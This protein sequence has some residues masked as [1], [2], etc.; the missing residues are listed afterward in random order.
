MPSTVDGEHVTQE[1]LQ[2]WNA[3]RRRYP[4]WQYEE[5]FVV[6][7][8]DGSLSTSPV[9]LCEQL[10]GLRPGFTT[11]LS[12]GQTQPR[13]VALG[14][15]W[16]LPTAMWILFLLLLGSVQAAIPARPYETALH[17]VTNLWHC[18]RVP[19]GPPPRERDTPNI[20][21]AVLLDGSSTMDTA[22]RHEP[23][24]E[25]AGPH[26]ELV[27][28]TSKTVSAFV[29][30]SG[31]RDS[32]H[33]R[34]GGRHARSDDR[35]VPLTTSTCTICIPTKALSYA[36]T[37]PDSPSPTVE[38]PANGDLIP[39]A[40]AWIPT[41]GGTHSRSDVRQDQKTSTRLRYQNF[42]TKID[43]TSTR[44]CDRTVSI[45]TGSSCWMRSSLR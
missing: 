37:G 7:W 16:H 25:G 44:S 20:H 27:F 4:P 1:T 8:P 10:Q 18:T 26:V 38:L 14:N 23:Y 30:I 9:E 28:A 15:A 32:G 35:L 34:P 33:P 39:R 43:S 42:L 21:A 40:I 5:Q 36:D 11:D 3:D 31:R 29:S 45:N 6:Q 19:F 24:P 2:R 13:E 17:K 22:S 41:H 12:D